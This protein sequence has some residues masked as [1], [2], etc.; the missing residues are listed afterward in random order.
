MDSLI[1]SRMRFHGH[2]GVL[3]E[4][5]RDGQ[6]FEVTVRLKLSLAEAGKTDDLARAIDYRA[7][8]EQVRTVME[9]PPRKLIEAL[10]EGVAA[11][12]LRA[13]PSVGEV[14]VEI[15]KPAPPVDFV[16]AGAAVQ[17]VRRRQAG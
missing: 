2:H 3:P 11:G 6:W 16:F 10:A 17:I 9:G 13:F 8:H 5:R 1:L 4:E 12:L 15:L 7:V 14:E